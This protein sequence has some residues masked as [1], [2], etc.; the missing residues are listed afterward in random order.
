MAQTEKLSITDLPAATID[1]ACDEI[2]RYTVAL[3]RTF[4]RNGK[5]DSQLVGTGTLVNIEGLDCILTADH[6]LAVFHE[7]DRVSLMSSFT[8]L[9]RGHEFPLSHLDIH[10][11]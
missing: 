6:V 2:A 5:P 11:I 4:R 8:G 10:R 9:P 1:V 3:N 7:P